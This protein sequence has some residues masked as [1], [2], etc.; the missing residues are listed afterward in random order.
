MPPTTVSERRRASARHAAFFAG[1]VRLN[2]AASSAAG[3]RK[4]CSGPCSLTFG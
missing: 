4:W 1:S 3:T 2:Q